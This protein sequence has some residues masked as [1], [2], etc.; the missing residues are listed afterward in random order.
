VDPAEAL[1]AAAEA[2]LTVTE[3]AARLLGVDYEAVQPRSAI[4]ASTASG[5]P[6]TT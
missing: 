4:A 3:A 6:V 2:G 5:S 1:A